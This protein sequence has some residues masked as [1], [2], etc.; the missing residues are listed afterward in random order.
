[1]NKKSYTGSEIAE[2]VKGEVIGDG[3]VVIEGV[4][5]LKDANASQLS[6]VGNRKYQNQ[7]HEST[8]GAVLICKDLRD[9]PHNG[10][11]LIVCDNVDLSFSTV[12]G[13]FAPAPAVYPREIHDTA[14]VAENA[15]IGNNVHI[16]ANAIIDAGAEIG[17]N[18]VVC[19]GCYIGQDVRI[20]T[21]NLIYPNVTILHRCVLGN[22]NIIHS[23]VVIG[24]DGFGFLPTPTGIV[25]VPQTG[26]VRIGNNVEIGANTTVDRAR[27]GETWIKDNV[28]IDDQVMVAHNVVIGENT[29]LVAQCGIAG[30]AEIGRG[31]ILAA[32]VG[33]NGHI[34][35][36]DGVQV[37][38]TSG[39]VKSVEPGKIVMGTPAEG[40]REFMARYTLPGRFEK[41]QG[42]VAKLTAELEELKSKLQ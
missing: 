14:A 13:L 9:E 32:K 7:M 42:K 27:F 29:I 28:K 25:K 36:G 18:S 39:V 41:L 2:L 37:A 1:M 38:G 35:I 19:A 10:K 15:R 34:H 20:G 22:N 31:V 33:I 8:A 16:G 40:Q 4:A 30:S 26:I 5:S 11:C 3:S 21:G 17:D 24:A 12:I 6:F 23:G